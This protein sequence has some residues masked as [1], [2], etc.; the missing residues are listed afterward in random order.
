MRT[1]N[2]KIY[3]ASNEGMDYSNYHRVDTYDEWELHGHHDRKGDHLEHTDYRISKS[4]HVKSMEGIEALAHVAVAGLHI[5]FLVLLAVVGVIVYVQ[6]SPL[7]PDTIVVAP[8]TP[9]ILPDHVKA[10]IT[11][12]G[13]TLGAK[14]SSVAASVNIASISSAVAQPAVLESV[15]RAQGVVADMKVALANASDD[16]AALLALVKKSLDASHDA[17]PRVTTPAPVYPWPAS[18]A[19][20]ASIMTDGVDS[21]SAL[22]NIL[23]SLQIGILYDTIFHVWPSNLANRLLALQA[24]LG[25]NLEML[26]VVF[27]SA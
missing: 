21:L 26:G 25:A 13:N 27:E 17:S 19:G 18:K 1:H 11:A 12:A 9:Y 10:T 8:K 16:A 7:L 23:K 14:A 22:F 5:A 2:F 4:K 3:G 20:L 24:R 15:R 6:L